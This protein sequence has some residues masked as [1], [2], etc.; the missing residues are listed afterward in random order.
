MSMDQV[1]EIVTNLGT[2]GILGWYL[3]Y[4]TSVSEPKRDDKFI[5]GMDKISADF[6]VALAAERADLVNVT[7]DTNQTVHRIDDQ[8]GQHHGTTDGKLE[9]ILENDRRLA[10]A[11]IN[12]LVLMKKHRPELAADV[13]HIV[14]VLREVEAK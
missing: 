9:R 2:A 10:R 6:T 1:V 5:A 8:A 11:L 4:T 3:W 13:E 12:G 14:S 7:K